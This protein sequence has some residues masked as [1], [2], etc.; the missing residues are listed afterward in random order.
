MTLTW[1]D[2][3]KA[4]SRAAVTS[5]TRRKLFLTFAA[6]SLCGIF[7]VF[8][9]ALALETTPWISLSLLFLPI[10]LSSALLLSLGV[11]LIRMYMHEMKGLTLSMGR[12]F[13]GSMDVMIGTSYLSMPPVLAY[14]VLWIVLGFFFLLREIPLIGPFMNVV[15]AFG[16]FL[17]IFCSILLCLL[18]LSLL[19][20][21]APAAAHQSVKR[22]DLA[23]RVGLTIGAN[24]LSAT[25]LFLV[26]LIP[27]IIIGGL[28]SVSAM[29]TNVSFSIQGPTLA[30]ALEWFFVMLPFCALLAPAVVFF[31]HFAAESYQLLQKR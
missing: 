7:I 15:L 22:L 14:L 26:A 17:I 29:L 23:K 5:L 24:P 31:F 4:F 19:F 2:F 21:I 16:P 9:R 25:A 11:L 18:N 6:L 1:N 3:E 10:L 28:L 30:I 12:L 8:C 13:T 27:S 20:F